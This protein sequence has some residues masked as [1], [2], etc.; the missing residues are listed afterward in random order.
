M[1]KTIEAFLTIL[2]EAIPS[3]T[4]LHT[5]ILALRQQVAV[6]KRERSRPSLR[7][8]DRVFRVVLSR[9]WRAGTCPPRC[10]LCCRTGPLAL[11]S[12]WDE[13][14]GTLFRIPAD[15]PCFGPI[16]GPEGSAPSCRPISRGRPA[17]L[18][19]LGLRAPPYPR[20]RPCAI[21]PGTHL[22]NVP[23]PG[24]RSTTLDFHN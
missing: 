11:R 9:L 3:R 8:V 17:R 24:E 13:W 12:N 18:S 4:A 16:F 2:R 1:H 20:P 21:N 15:W 10:L 23:N 5:E 14:K 22:V 19:S 6:L 7:M